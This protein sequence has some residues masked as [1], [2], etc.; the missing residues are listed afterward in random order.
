MYKL[1]LLSSRYELF[2]FQNEKSDCL[3]S[4]VGGSSLWKKKKKIA[5]KKIEK[6]K[7]WGKSIEIGVLIDW[8]RGVLLQ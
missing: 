6:E 2:K 7:I 1:Q 8:K 4:L 5:N 3:I